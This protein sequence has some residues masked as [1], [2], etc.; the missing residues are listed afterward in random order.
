MHTTQEG[1]LLRFSLEVEISDERLEDDDFD[2]G[3]WRAEWERE[4]KP[5]L[6]RA[7]FD[8]LRESPQW[9]SHVRNRGISSEDEVEVVLRRTY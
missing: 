5:R 1:F 2:E 4:L 6:L 8:A 9:A 7:V 3:V